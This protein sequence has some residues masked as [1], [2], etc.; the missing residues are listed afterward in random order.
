MVTHQQ[1]EQLA[2]QAIAHYAARCGV[3]TPADVAHALEMMISKAARGIEKYCGTEAAIDVTV[4]TSVHLA[5]RPQQ[6]SKPN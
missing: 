1:S 4:R 3:Q 6:P 5:K 2:D